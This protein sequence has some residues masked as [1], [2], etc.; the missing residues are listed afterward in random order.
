MTIHNEAHPLAGRTVQLNNK[1]SDPITNDVVPGTNYRVEDWCDRVIGES[2]MD[3]YGNWAAKGYKER[4]KLTELPVDDE[5]V[6]GKI[7]HLWYLI[8]VTELENNE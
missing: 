5:V 1:A 8:H 2:W 3:A 6:Y 7:G 4:A